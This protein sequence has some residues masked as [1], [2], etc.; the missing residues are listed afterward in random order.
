[1]KRRRRQNPVSLFAFQDIITGL[2]GVMIFLVMVQVVDVVMA[3]F[4]PVDEREE[5][6]VLDDRR[7]ELREE[8]RSLE[9]ELQDVR[10][11]AASAIVVPKDRA[12]PGEVEK[13]A[14]A[15]SEK[16][17]IV[18][19]LV[20]QVHDLETRVELARKADAEDREKVKEMERIRR[21][22]EQQVARMKGRRGITLIPER[23]EHKI[24]I[25]V[26][27]SWR[28]A[29]VHRPFEK[30][31]TVQMFSHDEL[32][33]SFADFLDRLD[34][35]THSFVLLVRPSGVKEMR[36]LVK[37]LTERNFTYGRDPLE[38]DVEIAFAQG[39]GR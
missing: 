36:T 29:E 10:M 15:M 3:R 9:R 6:V 38:E 27:C 5:E 33:G 25:Y 14:E 13:L 16:E 35:T 26:V 22:L 20:S 39:G 18:A 23:G 12:R 8:I 37:A 19:A 4:V 2:C 31:K 30:G 7:A 28:G 34:Q 1:M 32:D 17:R 21:L 11:K 24:P